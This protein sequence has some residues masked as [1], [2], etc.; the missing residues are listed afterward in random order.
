MRYFFYG[1]LMDRE[2]LA[3]VLGRMPPS[4]AFEPAQL[5]GYARYCIRDEA[6]PTLVPETGAL[7]DGL[8][9][10]DLT[11]QDAARIAWYETDDYEIRESAVRRSDGSEILARC[12]LPRA[13]AAHD[14]R[15]WSF[16]AWRRRD[17]ELA[18]LLA[19]DW[20]GQFGVADFD[21]AERSYQA[22]KRRLLGS[23]D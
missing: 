21:R 3:V 10:H 8:L 7:A 20:M 6:F 17:R 23:G 13:E 11:P 4:H 14:G 12:C 5:D 15:P 18:L 9:V 2:L 19:R 16:D 22:R 1:T